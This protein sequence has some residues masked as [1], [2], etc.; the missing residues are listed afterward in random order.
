[1]LLFRGIFGMDGSPR[2]GR[3]GRVTDPPDQTSLAWFVGEVG[4]N[5][6]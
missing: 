6:R 3:L 1:M 4:I 2:V 5:S